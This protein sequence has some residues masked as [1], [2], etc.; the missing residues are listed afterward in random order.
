LEDILVNLIGQIIAN[1]NIVDYEQETKIRYFAE[2]YDNF[3]NY[4]AG[5][6]QELR[7]PLTAILP[8]L[9]TQLRQLEA[10][11]PTFFV[12]CSGSLFV[13]EDLAQN[14]IDYYGTL[15]QGQEILNSEGMNFVRDYI[16]SLKAKITLNVAANSYED[17]LFSVLKDMLADYNID[18]G[19]FLELQ[20]PNEAGQ[21]EVSE[22]LKSSFMSVC[23][24][25]LLQALDKLL[26]VLGQNTSLWSEMGF[27]R[28]VCSLLLDYP[29]HFM[30]PSNVVKSNQALPWHMI[31]KNE[32]NYFSYTPQPDLYKL[33][34]N[35]CLCFV[36]KM[37]MIL[38]L[39]KN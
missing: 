25:W 24:L 13:L 31:V 36:D 4:I 34:N 7:Q 2:S 15:Q 9:K 1:L 14:D 5:F 35:K 12:K 28:A 16:D 29:A 27:Q 39:K 3:V 18:F 10:N 23:F 8:D 37:L 22:N 32:G 26:S 17:R 20:E 11:D 30:S 38:L 21:T 6:D 19:D 33:R